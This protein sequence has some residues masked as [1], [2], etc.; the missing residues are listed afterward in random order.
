L[1]A[2]ARSTPKTSMPPAKEEA[3]HP[4][5]RA[6]RGRSGGFSKEKILAVAKQMFA[7]RGFSGVSVREIA[8]ECGITLPTLYHFYGDKDGLYRSCCNAVLSENAALLNAAITAPGTPK[9]RIRR[10]TLT[11]AEGLLRNRTLRK[12]VQWEL[13][14]REGADATDISSLN[15]RTEFLLFAQEFRQLD[16]RSDVEEHAFAVYALALGL[17][18]TRGLIEREGFA[19]RIFSSPA[20]LAEYVLS[21]I[22]P[23][24]HWNN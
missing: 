17:V 15:F 6:G 10:F 24:V 21:T 3:D 12:L 2:Q 7:E 20:H 9:E 18:Q 1:T 19:H 11:L 13:L 4:P 23:N 16:V 5:V 22:L 14:R 8:T